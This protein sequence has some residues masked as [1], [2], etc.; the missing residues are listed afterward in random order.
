MIETAGLRIRAKSVQGIAAPLQAEARA[1]A[2]KIK[3][4]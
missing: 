1:E 3:K 2:L 4:I